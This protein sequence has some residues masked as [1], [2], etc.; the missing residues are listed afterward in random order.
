MPTN[1]IPTMTSYNTPSGVASADTEYSAG[2]EAWRAF[3]GGSTDYWHSDTS[4]PPHWIQYQFDTAV[5]VR[6][7][8]IS[9][10]G[11]EPPTSFEFWGSNDG[12]S[13]DTLGT[14]TV[15]DW[16]PVTI[17]FS[18]TAPGSY[19]YYRM[20]ITASSQSYVQLD[21]FEMYEDA[22]SSPASSASRVVG[23]PLIGSMIVHRDMG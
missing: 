12:S 19:A 11:N 16:S 23:S 14:Y 15:S 20:H 8:S 3:D 18:V 13:W 17:S 1:I 4:S 7:F 6:S 10:H 22:I 9:S 21:A 2:Y 5:T